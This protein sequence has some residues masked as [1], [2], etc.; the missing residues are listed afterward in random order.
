MIPSYL[1]CHSPSVSLHFFPSLLCLLHLLLYATMLPL[2]FRPVAANRS[3]PSSPPIRRSRTPAERWRCLIT[4]SVLT[5]S[6]GFPLP[7]HHPVFMSIRTAGMIHPL[8]GTGRHQEG[9]VESHT[10]CNFISK[11]VNYSS[12]ESFL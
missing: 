12:R 1:L 4:A 8:T 7:L 6:P 10:R 2:V 9:Y 11:S 3:V 5:V